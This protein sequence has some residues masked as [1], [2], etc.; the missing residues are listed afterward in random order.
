MTGGILGFT[1][2]L[3]GRG[4]ASDGGQGETDRGVSTTLFTCPSCGRT[5]ISEQMEVCSNCDEAVERTPNK[6]ELGI[7]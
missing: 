6:H 5:Y 2:S 7:E 3:F 1:R 4:D